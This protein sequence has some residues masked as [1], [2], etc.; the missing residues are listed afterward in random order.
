[1]RLGVAAAVTVGTV[2]AVIG[3][4]WMLQDH[5]IYFPG[6]DP[7]SAPVP[8]SE[9]KVETDDGLTLNAW[10]RS[11]GASDVRPVV[12]VF[13]GNAGNRAGR[14]PLGD[15]LAEAG[16]A[17]VLAEYRGY[18]GNPGRPSEAGL[19]A[20]V[21]AVVQWVRGE[22]LADGGLVY[23]GESLGAAVAI[24]VAA[25]EP[26]DALVLGSPFTSLVDVGRHHY[27][28]LPVGSLVRDEYLSLDRVKRGELTGVPALV[29]AGSG[30]R[31]VPVLQ[32]RTI[33]EALGAELYEVGGADHNDPSIR[34]SREM[35]ER[36]STFIER[37]LG[38][39]TVLDT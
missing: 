13:P 39:G 22:G 10:A 30:D 12:I 5:F 31:T 32:S 7:G 27:A 20:D 1:M 6:P 26:P 2:A 35:V 18:G 28:W 4:I 29:V 24:A 38:G 21:K 15:R 8:W 34:S 36:V 9:M 16:Y 33:A 3:G 23:F 25:E 19:T 17:V 11:D 37:V 14:V